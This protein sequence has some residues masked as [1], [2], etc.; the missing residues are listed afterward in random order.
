VL[1]YCLLVMPPSAWGFPTEPSPRGAAKVR[2]ITS[3]YTEDPTRG[4]EQR[5]FLS[6][7]AIAFRGTYFD[8]NDAC[9]P[10]DTEQVY[11]LVAKASGQLTHYMKADS[12]HYDTTILS[13]YYRGFNLP[14]RSTGASFPPGAYVWTVIALDC[15]GTTHTVLPYWNGFQVVEQ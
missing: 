10:V 1:L 15:T 2:Q 5:V 14:F 8:P 7:D 4:T 9:L 6:T 13:D 11:V 3:A 12:G